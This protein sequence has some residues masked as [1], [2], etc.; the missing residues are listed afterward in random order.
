MEQK[1]PVF[2]SIAVAAA[3]IITCIATFMSLDVAADEGMY[4]TFKPSEVPVMY[5]RTENGRLYNPAKGYTKDAGARYVFNGITPLNEDRTLNVSFYNYGIRISSMSYQVRDLETNQLLEDTVVKTSVSYEDYI[6]ATLPIKNLI[7]KDREYLLTITIGTSKN[8]EIKYYERIIWTDDLKVDEKLDFVTQFNAYTYNKDQLSAISQWI[9][10]DETGDNTNY[11]KV[12]IHSTRAQIGWGDLNCRIE[13]NVIPTIW[14]ISPTAAQISLDYRAVTSSSSDVYEAY[15]V[16]DYYRIRQTPETIYLMDYERR[17]EQIFDAYNDLQSSGRINLGIQSDLNVRVEADADA[18][19]KYSYFV[20]GGNLWCYSR[21]D[22]KFTC[23]FS[24]TA[25]G[26]YSGRE[27]VD[28]HEIRIISVDGDGNAWFSVHGYMNGGEHDGETGV[29]LFRYTYEDNIV[30][31]Y[32][33][34]PVGVPYSMM[35][36]NVGDVSYVKG[37]IYYVKVNQYLY[38]IDLTGGEYMLLT[39]EL[40]DGT[41]A[42]NQSGTRIAYHQNHKPEN[43]NVICIYDF[44]TGTEKFI[45]GLSYGSGKT[46]DYLKII[47]YIEDDLVYGMAQPSDCIQ[48]DPLNQIFPMYKVAVLS[49]GY[50]LMKL[51]SYDGIYV[52]MAEIDGMRVNLWR[53]RKN[54]EGKYEDISIDQILNKEENSD[55]RRIYTELVN[56]SAR[57]KEIYL[58]IPTSSGDSETLLVR[59]AREI[60]FTDREPFVLEKEY[61]FDNIYMIYGYG[62]W[63]GKQTSLRRAINSAAGFYGM[64]LDLDGGYVWKKTESNVTPTFDKENIT[65]GPQRYTYNLRG[66]SLENIIYYL[67]IGKTV[68]AQMGEDKYVY[69]YDYDNNNIIYYDPVV[70]QTVTLDRETANKKFIQWD[71]TFLAE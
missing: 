67:S 24:F 66:V 41:Y 15:S 48:N 58:N 14:E 55:S 44:E 22:N 21:G 35:K 2:K 33:Y 71:N 8:E 37:D 25:S 42:V 28:E 26:D 38:S 32:V 50:V 69:I 11:G 5:V 51:Y 10:T 12:N 1:L 63:I 13:G 64:V 30:K 20:Q 53:V 59:Y 29:S 56:T 52:N 43:C 18:T 19:G 47:G 61:R 27:V 31:E 9:E 40:Y 57:Q 3:F 16:K 54:E 17:T 4:T 36:G 45:N 68:A 60:Q 34:I 6:T 39:D 65:V 49:D 23:V 7:E 46:T 62:D 70:E